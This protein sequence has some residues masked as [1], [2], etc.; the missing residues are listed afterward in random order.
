MRSAHPEL[1]PHIVPFRC[2]HGFHTAPEIVDGLKRFIDTAVLVI[3][4]HGRDERAVASWMARRHNWHI[5][6]EWILNSP[7]RFIY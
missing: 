3:V 4:S 7:M 1:P 5:G 2:R 6:T